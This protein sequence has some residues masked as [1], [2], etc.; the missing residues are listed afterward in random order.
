MYSISLY[1]RF[2]GLEEGKKGRDSLRESGRVHGE[3]SER[4]KVVVKVELFYKLGAYSVNAPKILTCCSQT[5]P[6]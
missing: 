6:R 5:A 4:E 3:Q 2:E 1:Q